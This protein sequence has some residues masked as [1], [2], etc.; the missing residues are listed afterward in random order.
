MSTFLNKKSEEWLLD[1]RLL[2][3]VMKI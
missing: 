3:E 2:T 1:L